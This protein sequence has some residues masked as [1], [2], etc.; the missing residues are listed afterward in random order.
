MTL[1]L[2]GWGGWRGLGWL[3]SRFGWS[4]HWPCV[5]GACLALAGGAA[6]WINPPASV[7]SSLARLDRYALLGL[8]QCY[9]DFYHRE[10]PEEIFDPMTEYRAILNQKFDHPAGFCAAI[11]N[12]PLEA[13]RYFTL[14]AGN[15]LW[16]CVPDALVSHH[17]VLSED[18]FRSQPFQIVRVIL[19]LGALLGGARLCRESWKRDIL[20]LSTIIAFAGRNSTGRKLFLLLLLL[21]T[22]SV[23]IV[24]LVGSPRYFFCWTPLFYLGVAYCAESLLRAFS[25]RQFESLFI[26]VSFILL[27]SPNYL[28]PRPNR[29]FEAVRQVAFHVKEYPAVGGWWSEPDTVIALNGKARPISIWNGINQAEIEKGM[30]DILMIDPNFRN[31]KTWA[32]QR[33]FFERFERQP[34]TYGFKKA[35]GIPTGRFDIYYK[36]KPVPSDG[37]IASRAAAGDGIRFAVHDQKVNRKLVQRKVTEIFF[38]P[39][40][41]FC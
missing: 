18:H 2:A 23:A 36:P 37:R 21:F 38:T 16:H 15:N 4:R 39:S 8:G 14:N 40:S 7:V 41:T 33:D 31:S 20:S 12:N 26:A 24:L 5:G 3:K 32:D 30:I 9:A 22:S 25:L 6:L 29:E 35:N 28:A 27:C 13:L 10:H 34:E 19:I 11:R 17:R 1:I